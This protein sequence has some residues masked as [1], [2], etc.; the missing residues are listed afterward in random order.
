MIEHCV[1][2]AQEGSSFSSSLSQFVTVYPERR[3]HLSTEA[4]ASV[5][6]MADKISVGELLCCNNSIQQKN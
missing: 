2:Q 1:E 3:L 6:T 4:T 5:K